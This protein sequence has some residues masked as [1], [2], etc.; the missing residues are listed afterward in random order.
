MPMHSMSMCAKTWENDMD[1]LILKFC[2]VCGLPSDW[3]ATCGLTGSAQAYSVLAVRC[4]LSTSHP[5]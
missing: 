2:T 4:A 1:L 5:V 3:L